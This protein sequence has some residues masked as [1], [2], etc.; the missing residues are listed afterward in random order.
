MT[1]R[2][3]N[4][5]SNPFFSVIIPAHNA[6]EYIEVGLES[7]R[8]QTFQDFELIVVCDNCTDKTEQI[9][10]VYGATTYS[11]SFGRDGLARDFGIEHAHGDWILFMDDDDRFLHEFCFQ[12]IA[13]EIARCNEQYGPIDMLAFGYIFRHRG[14][15]APYD[16]ELFTPRIA[17]VWSKA[18]R[19]DLIGDARFGD[20]VF[21]S[22]TY[23]LRDMKQRVHTI[24]ALDMPIY[25][26]NFMRAGSQTDKFVRGIIRQSP[27]A[28]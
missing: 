17:H 16:D 20:A 28:E 18:W 9:A 3:V 5:M 11:V 21:C 4:R 1:G 13:D 15:K 23:F 2:K 19:R 12:Q 10:K 14:Y 24:G 6:E 8:T 7:I 22:D 25:Y 26:Y 27:V